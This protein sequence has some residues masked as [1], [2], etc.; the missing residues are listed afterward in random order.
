MHQSQLPH[1]GC[2]FEE[3]TRQIKACSSVSAVKVLVQTL[4]NLRTSPGRFTHHYIN[5]LSNVKHELCRAPAYKMLFN[6]GLVL[7]FEGQ[8]QEHSQAVNT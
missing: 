8:N 7:F 1:N 2:S 4:G 5:K 6:D 3:G